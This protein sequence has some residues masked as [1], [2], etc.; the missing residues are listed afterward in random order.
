M[1]NDLAEGT[2]LVS[3]NDVVAALWSHTVTGFGDQPAVTP[4]PELTAAEMADVVAFLRRLRQ[5][6]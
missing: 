5:A 2:S 3:N 1:A 4:W 6:P